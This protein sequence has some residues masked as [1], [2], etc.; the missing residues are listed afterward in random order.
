[1]EKA[2]SAGELRA[3]LNPR[4]I[5]AMTMQTVMFIAQS[6]GATDDATVHPIEAEE[7]W[8]FCARGFSGS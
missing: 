1:M 6:S 2:Y 3:D 8:T 7:V 4:R 5:A